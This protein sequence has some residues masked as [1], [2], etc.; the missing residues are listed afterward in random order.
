MAQGMLHN[1]AVLHELR[2]TG[3]VSCTRTEFAETIDLIARGIIDAEKY[4]TDILPLEQLQYAFEQQI[5]PAGH[6]LKTVIRP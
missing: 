3:S 2:L 6:V 4:V 5:S 1:R